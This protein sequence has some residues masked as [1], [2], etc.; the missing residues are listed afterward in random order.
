MS[1]VLLLSGRI[2][3]LPLLA[4]GRQSIIDVS[5]AANTL[6]RVYEYLI[7]LALSPGK[8][9]E[10]EDSRPHVF[11][12]LGAAFAVF[13]SLPEGFVRKPNSKLRPLLSDVSKADRDKVLNVFGYGSYY[14]I[15]QQFNP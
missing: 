4:A 9:L 8:V 12:A 11:V 1:N 6:Y 7:S 3:S 2:L 15:L 13:P 14:R 5:D 10:D